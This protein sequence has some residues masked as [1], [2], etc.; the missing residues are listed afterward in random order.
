MNTA[1]QLILVFCLWT[2]SPLSLLRGQSS[3]SCEASSISLISL[4]P[5]TAGITANFALQERLNVQTYTLRYEYQMMGSPVEEVREVFPPSFDLSLA[6]DTGWHQFT[7]LNQCL[8]GDEHLGSQL[9]LDLDGGDLSCPIPSHLSIIDYNAANIS[10]QWAFNELALSWHVQYEN[11]EGF[12]E[13]YDVMEPFVFQELSP[14]NFHI[15]TIY[16]QCEDPAQRSASFIRQSPSIQFMIITVDD[17][18]ALSIPCMDLCRITERAYRLNCTRHGKFEANQGNFLATHNC[19]CLTPVQEAS[20]SL[21]QLAYFPNPAQDKITLSF[22][23]PRKQKCEV[24]LCDVSGKHISQLIPAGTFSA[25]F[26]QIVCQ[27]PAELTGLYWL[28]IGHENQF[29]YLKILILP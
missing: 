18:K 17:I 8:E 15:F 14:S 21:P 12:V 16:T 29:Q 11:A 28:Q 3:P 4:T 7:I 19:N 9:R 27:L 13:A 24:K 1:A 5:G 6:S 22:Q 25:G 20:T 2:L 23:L 26:H 10:F